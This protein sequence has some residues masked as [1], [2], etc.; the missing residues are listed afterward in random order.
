[1]ACIMETFRSQAFYA[2][3]RILIHGWKLANRVE[4]FFSA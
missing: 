3:R 4:R 1:M 2:D